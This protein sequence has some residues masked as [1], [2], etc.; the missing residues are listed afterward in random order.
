MKLPLVSSTVTL[1]ATESG[2]FN[3][4]LNHYLLIQGNSIKAVQRSEA[5]LEENDKDVVAILSYN[6]EA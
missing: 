1:Q 3:P 5:S 6:D 2:Q 4:L